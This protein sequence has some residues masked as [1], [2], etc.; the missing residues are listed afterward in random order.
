MAA[1]GA[2]HARREGGG[3]VVSEDVE[4]DAFPVL[5]FLVTPSV[6]S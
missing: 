5:V 1:H 4:E 6:A 3:L 2:G